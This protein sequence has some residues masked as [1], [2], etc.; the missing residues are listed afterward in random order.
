MLEKFL[1]HLFKSLSDGKL[2]VEEAIGFLSLIVD[3]PKD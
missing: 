3:L 2:S 1:L